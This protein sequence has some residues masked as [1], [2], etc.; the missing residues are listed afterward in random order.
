MKPIGEKIE[1]AIFIDKPANRDKLMTRFHQA[2]LRLNR[3]VVDT[4]W[5]AVGMHVDEDRDETRHRWY[6]TP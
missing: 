3:E 1:G 6:E 5:R 4:V 2:W